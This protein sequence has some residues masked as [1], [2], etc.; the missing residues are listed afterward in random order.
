MPLEQNKKVFRIVSE[1]KHVEGYNTVKKI[2][3]KKF[4][5]SGNE[6]ND[7]TES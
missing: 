1:E 6:E 5:E 4:R 3:E 2:E 7:E